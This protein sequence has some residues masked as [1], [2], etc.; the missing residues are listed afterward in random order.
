MRWVIFP[1]GRT[2]TK[3]LLLKNERIL[4]KNLI[5]T[6]ADILKLLNKRDNDGYGKAIKIHIEL[7]FRFIN[8]DKII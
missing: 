3:K 6:H 5:I 8:N 4:C 2:I 7:Y 1:R